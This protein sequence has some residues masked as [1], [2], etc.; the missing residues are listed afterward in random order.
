MR[1]IVQVGAK[2]IVYGPLTAK[3]SEDDEYKKIFR[4]ILLGTTI[5]I[6]RFKY[7]EALFQEMPRVKEICEG[8]DNIKWQKHQ[9]GVLRY[10]E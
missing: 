3:M 9:Y 8:R 7:D 6:S 1:G 5:E 10:Y 2:K 4:Q